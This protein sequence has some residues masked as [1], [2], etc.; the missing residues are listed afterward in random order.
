MTK[1]AKVT[2]KQAK[3]AKEN[4]AAR[5]KAGKGKNPAAKAGTITA[6][7]VDLIPLPKS[8][9]SV[10]VGPSCLAMLDN[11]RADFGQATELLKGVE[12]AKF[13]IISKVTLAIVKAARADKNIN[14]AAV[15]SGDNK[16]MNELHNQLG[17]ALGTRVIKNVTDG[18]STV[19]RV[20]PSPA[21]ADFFLKHGEKKDTPDGARKETLRSN[22]TT[23][24]KRAAG[25]ACGII[26]K[27]MK[28][29]LDK[30]AGTLL[31][32][33]PAVKTQFGADKVLLNENIS[34]VAKDKPLKARPSFTAIRDMGALVHNASPIGGKS[35]TRTG[36]ATQTGTAPAAINP[37]KAFQDMATT[38]AMALGKFAGPLEGKTKESATMLLNALTAKLQEVGDS[39]LIPA[40]K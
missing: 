6:G 26:D 5:A 7:G 22:W 37:D 21:V 12:S 28:A 14:L 3:A 16:Q 29:E 1:A 38:M 13:A 23:L 31:L 4:E 2:G 24:V 15:Y 8:A 10:D 27:G 35:N 39:K 11:A 20:V 40:A 25:T 9:L 18:D 30:K 33:G 17:I 34:Q 36:G 32:S 19:S